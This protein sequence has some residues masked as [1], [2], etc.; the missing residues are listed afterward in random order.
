MLAELVA[1]TKK[2]NNGKAKPIWATEFSYYADDTPERAKPAEHMVK[3]A[4]VLQTQPEVERMYWYLS[5]DYLQQFHN[6]GL[7]HT[8]ADPMGKYTPVIGYAAYSNL[9]HQFYHA[10]FDK[11]VATDSRTRVYQFARGGQLLWVCW[12]STG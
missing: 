7:I 5:R 9:I 12:S 1:L 8:E 2:Y 11:R 3:M 4:T 10:T 6:L